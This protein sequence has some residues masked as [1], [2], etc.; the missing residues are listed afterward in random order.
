[1]AFLG[2]LGKALGLDSETGKGFAEGLA[3]SVDKSIQNDMQ[4]TQD[5]IDDLTK[6][7]FES[8][9]TD[10]K[11]FEKELKE[12][13]EIVEEIMANMG[14][15]EGIKAPLAPVAAQSL[16]TQL[17]LNQALAQS[18]GY[19]KNFINYGENPIKELEINKKLNGEVPTFT[20]SDLAKSTVSPISGVD[21]SQLGDSANVGFMKANFFGGA[22]DSS[23]E[24]ETRSSALLKAA[25]VDIESSLASKLPAAIQVKLDPLILGMQDNPKAEEVRLVTMLKNTDRE[26]NPELYTRIKNKIDLTRDIMQAVSPKKGLSQAETNSAKNEFVQ[27]VAQNYSLSTTTGGPTGNPFVKFNVQNEKNLLAL[28]SVNYYMREYQKSRTNSGREEAQNNY[29]II[30]EAATKGVKV[31][32]TM[33][34]DIYTVNVT[35]TPFY[36]SV[37]QSQLAVGKKNDGDAVTSTG[38]G[39][40][41]VTQVRQENKTGVNNPDATIKDLLPKFIDTEDNSREK[42]TLRT[43]LLDAIDEKYKLNGDFKKQMAML[44]ELQFGQKT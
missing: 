14:G 40:K 29:Q 32:G 34:D 1:M 42:T 27:I 15:P 37:Q 11:R 4:R 43:R 30:M 18:R 2:S 8:T 6:I 41:S 13:T 17:G 21:M 39:V 26:T 24:I 22:Q 33:I 7:S 10:K 20:M 38:T 25:G 44:K 35:D 23:K 12:N 9:I 28:E 3:S 36:S 19:K 16:I 5:N 31:S